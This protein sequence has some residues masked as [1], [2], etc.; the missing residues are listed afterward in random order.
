MLLLG[1]AQHPQK[2]LPF[3]S[4]K[5]RLPFRNPIGAGFAPNPKASTTCSDNYS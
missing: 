1:S 5:G 2:A 3:E 4:T